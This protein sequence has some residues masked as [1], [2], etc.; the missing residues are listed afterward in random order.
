MLRSSR[1]RTVSLFQEI[2]ILR[3]GKGRSSVIETPL[4]SHVSIVVL[5][6][7]SLLQSFGLA[8]SRTRIRPLGMGA[9]PGANDPLGNWFPNRVSLETESGLSR[10]HF[11][12]ERLLSVGQCRRPHRS[13]R[14]MIVLFKVRFRSRLSRLPRSGGMGR[15]IWLAQT[16]GRASAPFQEAAR[17][18]IAQCTPGYP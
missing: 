3:I 5:A 15:P 10:G 4:E 6:K 16:V 12:E 17:H 13:H 9:I 7:P 11:W 14:S 2:A 8:W 1:G 18:A